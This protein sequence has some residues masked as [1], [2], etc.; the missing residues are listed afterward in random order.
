M[1]RIGTP[2]VIG[3][4]LVLIATLSYLTNKRGSTALGLAGILL[5]LW[6]QKTATQELERFTK[7]FSK[8]K[9][10][11]TA[12]LYDSLFWAFMLS[13]GYFYLWRLKVKTAILQASTDLTREAFLKPDVVAQNAVQL[14]SLVWFFAIS[15]SLLA[16][17]IFAAYTLSRTLIWATIAGKK[18][19]KKRFIEW[20]KLNAIW[21]LLWAAPLLFVTFV[22]TKSSQARPLLA[23]ASMLFIYF[24]LHLHAQFAKIEK[25]GK[26]ITRGVGFAISKIPQ[27][28]LPASFSFIAYIVAYQ[29][30]TLTQYLPQNT[31]PVFNLIFAALYLN[32]LRTYLYPIISSFKE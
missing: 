19:T 25:I 18:L 31:W 23:I 22:T 6:P 2:R 32:W 1:K 8:M 12:S 24:T 7:S 3:I 29:A 26:S 14:K 11:I 20:A 15:L 4:I 5:I 17:S 21:W 9:E 10:A 27:L 30:L 28:I 16:I 13:A